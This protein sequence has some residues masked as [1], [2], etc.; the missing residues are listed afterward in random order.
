MNRMHPG[1]R[2]QMGMGGMPSKQ[3]SSH[4]TAGGAGGGS[5]RQSKPADN[6]PRSSVNF[7][8]PGALKQAPDS[9]GAKAPGQEP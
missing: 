8:D 7:G 2:G 1:S 6:Q 9:N 4:A 3:R 5:S